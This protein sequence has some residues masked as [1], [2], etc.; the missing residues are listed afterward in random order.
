MNGTAELLLEDQHIILH[1]GDSIYFDANL[2]HR[3]LSTRTDEVKV[4]AV[5]MR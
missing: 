5:V 2:K 1:E 3:L 4:L